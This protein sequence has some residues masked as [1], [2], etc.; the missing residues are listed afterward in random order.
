VDAVMN[1]PDNKTYLFSGNKMVE[2]DHAQ[3]W[4][5]EPVALNEK[6]HGLP[7]ELQD[8]SRAVSAAIGGKDGKAYL[9]YGD[10]YLRFSGPGLY[11]TDNGYPKTISK[12]W[13][14]IKNNIEKTGRVDAAV[15]VESQL[16]TTM[17]FNH[18]N[19]NIT[20]PHAEDI[21]LDGNFTIEFWI[22][23]LKF[24]TLAG[25][26]ISIIEKGDFNM[27]LD[28]T[29]K[30]R[31]GD[32]N[33]GITLGKNVWTHL[34]LVCIGN[35]ITVYAYAN[36]TT[37]QAGPVDLSFTTGESPLVIAKPGEKDGFIG[38]MDDIRVWNVVR[39]N[40]DV[41]DN[42]NI[43]LIGNETGLA[44]YYVYDGT[45]VKDL[46]GNTGGVA[47]TGLSAV[48]EEE[49]SPLD[50][51]SGPLHT[52]LFS[53]DQFYRYRGADYT[54]VEPGYPKNITQLNR[55]SRFTKLGREFAKI[56]TAYADR[57][58]V[59][60]FEGQECYVVSD[61]KYMHYGYEDTFSSVSCAFVDNGAIY[62][63]EDNV[64]NHISNPEGAEVKK[65]PGMPPV[66]REV[67]GD[68]QTGLDAVLK[69]TDGNTY[70]FKGA[71]YYDLLHRKTFEAGE[72]WGRVR[73]N[74]DANETIDAAF[75]GRDGKTYVFS[76]NQYFQYTTQTYAGENA[77]RAPKPIQKYWGGL[78]GVALA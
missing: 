44:A 57:R 65:T 53:G 34:A 63:I 31:I 43:Q 69:G 46:T 26:P 28:N 22:N 48:T 21:A 47:S 68:F 39:S 45:V 6:W 61:K 24:A 40:K 29:G 78:T 20:V 37:V 18:R 15:V 42:R 75:V 13:G 50:V 55:E 38:Y 62:T 27:L 36:N 64:W 16:P 52:Y 12:Y 32:A 5:S 58:N 77:E 66:L 10:K 71:A 1:T 49:A 23:P 7:Q 70:L 17:F 60:L 73:N 56:D 76:G 54:T 25:E 30:V 35:T 2:Y 3:R 8:G 14:R 67:P 33:P 19:D 41:Q 11:K 9:F 72:Q 4:W 59:Y 51:V 74:I